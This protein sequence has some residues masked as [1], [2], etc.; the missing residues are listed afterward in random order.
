MGSS[1]SDKDAWEDIT[2]TSSLPKSGRLRV[3]VAAAVPKG[4]PLTQQ[5]K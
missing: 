4:T 2:S 3:S 1:S 5:W